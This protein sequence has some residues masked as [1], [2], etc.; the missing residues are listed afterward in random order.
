MREEGETKKDV[1]SIA[2]LIYPA[3]IFTYQFL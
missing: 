1:S 3:I 2:T